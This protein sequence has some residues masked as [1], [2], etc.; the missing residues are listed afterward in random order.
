MYAQNYT[1]D[2]LLVKK[3]VDI[4]DPTYLLFKKPVDILDKCT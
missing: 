2:V 1:Q 3:P 4:L